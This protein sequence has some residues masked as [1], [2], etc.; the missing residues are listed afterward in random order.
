MLLANLTTLFVLPG[1]ILIS[2]PLLISAYI[3]ACFSVLALSFRVFIF[4]TEFCYAFIT[5][6][7]VIPTPSN[8]SLLPFTPSEPTSPSTRTPNRRSSECEHE[9]A[10][11]ISLPSSVSTPKLAPIG[12]PGLG[13]SKSAAFL[14]LVSGDEDRDFEGLGGWRCYGAGAGPMSVISGGQRGTASG[15]TSSVSSGNQND[16]DDDADERA[17][18]SIN[19][20]LELPS[21]PPTSFFQKD[22]ITT[23]SS[24]GVGVCESKM[25]GNGPSSCTTIIPNPN[26]KRAVT[27]S[28][29]ARASL[30]HHSTWATGSSTGS[31]L[32]ISSPSRLVGRS[33]PDGTSSMMSSSPPH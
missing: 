15:S 14:G 20:R 24:D 27:T 19:N 18:L 21:P 28:M 26:H 11:V 22:Y 17:W 4:Y 5:S 12:R 33:G 16:P 1:L 32:P 10:P 8:L 29:F 13:R 2:I 31:W 30:N 23:N 7:F 9:A 25:W 6:Y 3:T